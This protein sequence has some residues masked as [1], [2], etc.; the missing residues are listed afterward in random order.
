MTARTEPLTE[1]PAWNALKANRRVSVAPIGVT[2]N[3]LGARQ[4]SP[5]LSI[6]LGVLARRTCACSPREHAA[7]PRLRFEL[8]IA[9]R[10]RLGKIFG[11]L[12]EEVRFAADSP[13]ER[14][15]FELPVPASSCWP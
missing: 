14:D 5:R 13:V 10:N 1:R 11:A 9:T 15:G 6:S 2:Q 12:I 3:R 7:S 4:S 8:A